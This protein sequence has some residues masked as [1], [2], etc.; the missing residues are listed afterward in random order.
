[1]TKLRS[2]VCKMFI[3]F[4]D[5]E[6][7]ESFRTLLFSVSFVAFLVNESNTYFSIQSVAIETITFRN[8]LRNFIE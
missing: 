4:N 5:D 2:V 6:S 3:R 7:I 1:M 8:S